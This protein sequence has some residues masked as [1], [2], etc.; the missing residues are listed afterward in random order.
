MALLKD[1]FKKA[2]K[3]QWVSEKAKN[4]RKNSVRRN[5]KETGFKN[6]RHVYCT[7]CRRKE[8]FDYRYSDDKGKTR[9]LSSQDFL[10][11]RDRVKEK[12]LDWKLENRYYGNKVAKKVGLPLR[13]LL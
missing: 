11:L 13:D 2:M 6:V 5:V 9:Y 3:G 8:F 10:S 12:G 7:D 1:E 4:N